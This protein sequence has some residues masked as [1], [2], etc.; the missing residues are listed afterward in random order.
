VIEVRAAERG[1]LPWIRELLDEHWGGQEQIVNGE[2]YR[3]ADLP[4]LVA[5]IDGERVGYA[6]LRV[7]DEV[8]EIGLIHAIRPRIGIGTALVAAL[9]EAAQTRGLRR[10]RAVTTNDNRE[11]QAFC[12]RLGFDLV[13]V[14]KGAVTRGRL[15][16][17]TIP[18]A[19][20]DGTPIADEWV[21]ERPLDG[22]TEVR[23]R[24]LS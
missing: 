21:Y 22:P 6:A 20:G 18:L 17:P 23:D 19:S 12:R 15:V 3:P 24:G 4:G 5:A 11:A 2:S 1:D 16:K 10:L 8:A 9:A 7:V 13:E 14:R